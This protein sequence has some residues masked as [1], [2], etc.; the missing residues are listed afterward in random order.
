MRT[1]DEAP[2]APAA[3]IGGEAA[4][5]RVVRGPRDQ[6]TPLGLVRILGQVTAIL[7]VPIVGGTIAG[8]ALDRILGTTPLCVL[9]GFGLGNVVAIVGIA[10]LIRSGRRKYGPASSELD[11]HRLGGR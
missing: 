2:D 6:L 8:I 9:A 4:A 3:T 5:P 10:L 11:L 7:F 1:Q